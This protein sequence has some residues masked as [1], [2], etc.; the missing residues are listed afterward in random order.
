MGDIKVEEVK[1][2]LEPACAASSLT[3]S[4]AVRSTLT[5]M[6]KLAWTAEMCDNKSYLCKICCSSNQFSFSVFVR[7]FFIII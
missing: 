6:L 3:E 5:Q 2:G 7:V 1:N 4:A